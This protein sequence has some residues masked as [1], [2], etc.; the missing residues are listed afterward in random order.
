V[1]PTTTNPLLKV[2]WRRELRLRFL[3]RSPIILMALLLCVVIATPDRLLPAQSNLWGRLL[4]LLSF[5]IGGVGAAVILMEISL[6]WAG[7]KGRNFLNQALV[8]Q[9]TARQITRA[10]VR[11]PLARHFVF[12]SLTATVLQFYAFR[13]EPDTRAVGPLLPLLNIANIWATCYF[14]LGIS[15]RV[16]VTTGHALQ[17]LLRSAIFLILAPFLGFGILVGLMLGSN[18][19]P[20]IP[21][22]PV[23]WFP[24]KLILG[25]RAAHD[26]RRDFHHLAQRGEER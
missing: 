21:L 15:L 20:M 11:P 24:A 25:W 8:T 12:W 23:A 17:S 7:W 26:M 5:G 14:C 19:M 16:A 10:L 9:L 18:F 4:L 3:Y 13:L 1:K 2:M 22:L 6:H